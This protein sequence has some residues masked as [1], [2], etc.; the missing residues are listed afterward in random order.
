MFEVNIFETKITEIIFI[1]STKHFRDSCRSTPII[2]KSSFPYDKFYPKR[3]IQKSYPLSTNKSC[4][5]RMPVWIVD[6]IA[7]LTGSLINF[8]FLN[9]FNWA[10]LFWKNKTLYSN[11]AILG[12]QPSTPT[13]NTLPVRQFFLDK[14]TPFF[15]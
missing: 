9:N 8:K 11:I 2:L 15:S 3:I 10:W 13:Q 6:N 1:G 12:K 4:K 14:H 5:K 7:C